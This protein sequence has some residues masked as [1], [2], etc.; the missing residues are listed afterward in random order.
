MRERLVVEMNCLPMLAGR[1]NPL[2]RREAAFRWNRD[3]REPPQRR[4]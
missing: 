4:K 1:E 3:K 2:T